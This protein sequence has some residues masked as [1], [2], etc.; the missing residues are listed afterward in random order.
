MKRLNNLLLSM[1]FILTSLSPVFSEEIEK[2]TG[3]STSNYL[4]EKSSYQGEGYMKIGEYYFLEKDM[5]N[6]KIAV[7]YLEEAYKIKEKKEKISK[8]DKEKI[9]G[10]VCRRIDGHNL[11]DFELSS[12]E[13]RE[14]IEKAETYFA[15]SKTL[16]DSFKKNLF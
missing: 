9:L 4:E 11:K 5:E 16:V 6:L 8:K 1:P 7:N 3:S 12:R 10:I 14:E 13:I 15:N 2:N